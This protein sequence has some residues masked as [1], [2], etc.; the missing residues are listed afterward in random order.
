LLA[1]LTLLLCLAP[2]QAVE[3]GEIL[4]DPALEA[5]ARRLSQELRCVVCQNQSIDESNAP[6]AHDLR[7]IVRERL[8]AGDSD[9]EVLAFVEARYGSFVLLRPRLK[10]QTVLL[11]LTPLLLLAGAAAYLVR[12]RQRP[13]GVSPETAPLSAA[14]QQRLAEL[15]ESGSEPSPPRSR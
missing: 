12:A 10:P 1:A 6:L 4:K 15:L 5:R 14:E 13:A 8:V 7:V 9:A 11:W 3:P 2:T